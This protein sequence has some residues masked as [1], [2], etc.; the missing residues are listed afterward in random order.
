MDLMMVYNTQNYWIFGLSPT[1]G[2]QKKTK[3]HNVSD[4]GSLS[5]LRRGRRY[6][7]C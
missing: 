1:S 5:V 2:I 7:P 3:E 6:L 4:T